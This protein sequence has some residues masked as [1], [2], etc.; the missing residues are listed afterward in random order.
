MIAATIVACEILFWVLLLGGLTARYVARRRRLGAV[1]LAAAPL[2]DVV[3]LA[4]TAVD[5]RAGSEADWTH[6]LAA[7]Y[8][9]FSVAF[10]PM[11][12]RNADERFAARFGG[13]APAGPVRRPAR[14]PLAAVGALPRRLRG[15]QR[16]AGR[17]RARRRRPRPD[18]S[19]VA[20]RRLVR[21]ARRPER[22][23]ARARAAVD[24]RRPATS[25]PQPPT[26][27]RRTDMNATRTGFDVGGGHISQEVADRTTGGATCHG[28]VR[29]R[30]TSGAAPR[31][32]I[33]I[34]MSII[35][36]HDV[37]KRYGEVAGPARRQLRRRPRRGVLPARPQRRRQDDD[38]RDPR[39]PPPA[40][41]RRG[42]AS[43]ATTPAAATARCATAS[44]S[45]CSPPASRRS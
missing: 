37:H 21:P 39:G 18:P 19:A 45:C 27:R 35:E 7:V 26:G 11:W 31:G 10:G 4:V 42:L 9:G 6:G 44:A 2:A 41:R 22:P 8:L 13:I 28:Q 32:G 17:A 36:V 14:R 23:V 1:L 5:L 38:H 34:G 16:R 20:G 29:P 15:G 43:S 25:A 40:E 24:R 3:L 30:G 33:V 12:M